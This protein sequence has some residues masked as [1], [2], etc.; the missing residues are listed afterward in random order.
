GRG[1][2]LGRGLSEVRM[3]EDVEELAAELQLYLL[4]NFEILEQGEVEVFEAGSADCVASRVPEAE[5]VVRR[6]NERGDVEVLIDRP[7][8]GGQLGGRNLIGTIGPA[9]VHRGGRESRG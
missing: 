6:L 9:G 3:V 2:H 8:A 4:A 1:A 5:R 7:L